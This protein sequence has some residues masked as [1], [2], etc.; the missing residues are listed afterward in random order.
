[1][2]TVRVSMATVMDMEDTEGME[3]MEDMEEDMVTLMEA[4]I[5]TRESTTAIATM[6]L[7]VHH[8]FTFE[9]D[10]V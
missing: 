4:T 6:N 5:T 2:T 7:K 3:D 8:T 1:M 10:K 9:D